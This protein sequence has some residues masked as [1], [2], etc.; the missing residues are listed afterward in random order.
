MRRHEPVKFRSDTVTD[1]D[2]RDGASLTWSSLPTLPPYIV[3]RP[4]GPDE[5]G[6][7][8]LDIRGPAIRATVNYMLHCVGQ[9]AVAALPAGTPSTERDARVAAAQA[10]A[11]QQLADHLNAA[12]PDARDHVTGDYLLDEGNNYSFEFDAFLTAYCRE[13]SGD[14]RFDFQAGVTSIPPTIARMARPFSLRQAYNLVP[15]FAAMFAS[16]DLRVITTTRDSARIQWRDR[17]DREMPPAVRSMH[18]WSFCQNLQGTLASLPRVIADQPMAEVKELRCQVHGDECCEWEFR[19][20]NPAQRG[21]F[22]ARPN[23]PSRSMSGLL[24]GEVKHPALT[25]N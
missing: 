16:T 6:R 25:K 19:W 1:A 18:T 17:V 20:Q 24:L 21:L 23:G 11:L 4:F 5:A 3:G 22:S 14:P 9:Q 13:I 2:I 8:I 12:L 15:R 7:P 10:V